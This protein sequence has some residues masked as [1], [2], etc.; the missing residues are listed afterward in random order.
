MFYAIALLEPVIC[1][2]LPR[3]WRT[4]TIVCCLPGAGRAELVIRMLNVGCRA[5]G[6]G[7]Q[8]SRNQQRQAWY[9]TYSVTTGWKDHGAAA[10]L[11]WWHK[12][13]NVTKAHLLGGG[14]A[15]WP[16]K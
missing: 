1:V 16:V 14:G 7:G 11:V 5:A 3:A 8:Q 6:G 12:A 13:V 9:N 2:A 10:K 4:E 15:E